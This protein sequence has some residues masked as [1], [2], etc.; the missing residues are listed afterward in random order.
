MDE[1]KEL[2]E[3]N[4]EDVTTVLEEADNP[5]VK[6]S[7]ENK[8]EKKKKAEKKPKEKKEKTK[9]TYGYEKSVNKFALAI[10]TLIDLIMAAGYIFDYTKGNIVIGF[11]A[12]V[13]GCV[14]VSMIADYVVYFIRRDS[15]TFRY[16]SILGYFAV[17][18]IALFGAKNDLVFLIVFPITVIYVL[19][20]DFKVIAIISAVFGVA[21]IADIIYVAAIMKH[22]HSGAEINSTSLILQGAPVIVFLIVLCG[23]TYISNKNNAL[24]IKDLK[25][26]KEKSTELLDA[27]LKVAD[28]VRT[29]TEKANN[30][31]TELG[32]DIDTTAVALSDIS[33]GNNSNA[34]SIEQQTIMT[35][36][37]QEM[38]LNTKEMSNEMLA[39]SKQSAEAVKGGKESVDN[40]QRQ[41]KHSKEANEKVVESV[42][43][44][45]KNANEVEEITTQI[46][47]ISSQTN[48]L[49]L[50]ASI[51]SARAGEAGRG[52]AVVADEIRKL[53]EQTR[54][55]TE[56][57]KNIV[58]QLEENASAAKTTV[59]DVMETANTEYELIAEADKQFEG[60][61]NRMDILNE[62]VQGIY[63]KI[64]EILQSNN[65][66][67]DSITQIS[68]VSEEVAVSTQQAVEMG[69]RTNEKA[70]EAGNLMGEL[71]K[72]VS[73]L[74]K[75]MN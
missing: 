11:A 70:R 65:V 25:E 2:F 46:F 44:L 27:V 55:L 41:A 72:S 48:L 58:V 75:Y 37:I 5:D 8:K 34:E 59:D 14:V 40:L 63:N 73:A 52:F 20:Y 16:V 62:N 35:S 51:E 71:M 74:D 60:I 31:I 69:D 29:N 68:A 56:G 1:N 10:I 30:Y 22:M 53:A 19:Y 38:I 3:E 43:N 49:A 42:T 57:I 7:E 21:N 50:N 64:E 54:E 61:G 32:K 24:K 45:I 12:A 26:E 33:Q 13:V 15:K 39:L 47:A 67:V 9:K 18:I 23:T 36:N 66:I 4:A 6:P 17:Y 28:V